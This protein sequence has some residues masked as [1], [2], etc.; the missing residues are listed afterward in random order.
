MEYE[1]ISVRSYMLTCVTV[2]VQSSAPG[3]STMSLGLLSHCRG[4]IS[5]S[6]VAVMLP[7]SDDVMS[8]NWA[9]L[10]WGCC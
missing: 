8:E 10:N 4:C 1:T 2:T 6:S 9:S 3:T 7:L 5:K